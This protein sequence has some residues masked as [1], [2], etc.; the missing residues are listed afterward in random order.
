MGLTSNPSSLAQRSNLWLP[1]LHTDVGA[2]G[3]LLVEKVVP[4][5]S[6]EHREAQ[7]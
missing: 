5:H 4:V 1:S 7:S 3:E 2:L 6:H